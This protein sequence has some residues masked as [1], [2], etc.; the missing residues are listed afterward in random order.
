MLQKKTPT[1]TVR[2]NNT[3]TQ[4]QSMCTVRKKFRSHQLDKTFKTCMILTF[5]HCA[6]QVAYVMY[7][8]VCI[9]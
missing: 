3:A 1:C 7:P 9:T 6:L 4:V 2:H 5:E 8:V